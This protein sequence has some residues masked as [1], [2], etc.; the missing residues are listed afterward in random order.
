MIGRSECIAAKRAPNKKY[1][2]MS[3][4]NNT[5]GIARPDGT[6][7]LPIVDV[8]TKRASYIEKYFNKDEQLR[9]LV[10]GTEEE[11]VKLKKIIDKASEIVS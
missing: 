2:K 3:G 7:S 11:K 4:P 1:I 9:I 5:G 8:K 10:S 6:W